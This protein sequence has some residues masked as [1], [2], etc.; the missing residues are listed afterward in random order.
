MII[1]YNVDGNCVFF[2]LSSG[3]QYKKTNAKKY[4]F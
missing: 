2:H 4:I 3:K 1:D